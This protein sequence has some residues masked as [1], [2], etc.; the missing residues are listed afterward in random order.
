MIAVSF[1]TATWENRGRP[2]SYWP[3]P[4]AV[5]AGVIWGI[6]AKPSEA[7]DNPAFGWEM[8]GC[9]GPA[10]ILDP[11]T[12]LLCDLGTVTQGSQIPCCRRP[13]R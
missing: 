11:S 4:M 12:Q 10:A 7:Y 8:S 2:R 13:Y 9:F 5:T 1:E 6:Q 3:E